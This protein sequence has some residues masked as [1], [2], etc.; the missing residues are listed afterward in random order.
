MSEETVN[1]NPDGSTTFEGAEETTMPPAEDAGAGTEEAFEEAA[2]AVAGTDP[3]I[4]L[5]LVAVVLGLLFF[6]YYRRSKDD[7]DDFFSNLDGEKFNL[8]LPAEVEEYYAIK[9]KVQASGWVPGTPPDK[10]NPN[11]PHRIMAQAL[12]KRAI[13]DIPIVTHIQKESP[14]MNKLYSQSMCS[15]KQWRAYQAAEAMVSA[16]VDEVRAE[17]DEIEPGWSQVIW[18]QAMQYHTMLKQKHEMEQKAAAEQAAKRKEIEEKVNNYKSKEDIEKE[19][20]QAA[21]KAAQELLKQEEREKSSKKAFSGGGVKKGFLDG[22]NKN[23][24]KK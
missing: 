22:G 1:I 23:K 8:K 13:G 18:R 7:G 20:E 2:E 9:E 5:G 16:E 17:A 11:G 21:E 6:I 24:K 15:V 12:M 19:K 4:Y 3:L 14:G 10:S